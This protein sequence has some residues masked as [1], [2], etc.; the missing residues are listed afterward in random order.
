MLKLLS[1]VQCPLILAQVMAL[2]IGLIVSME[3]EKTLFSGVHISL[4]Q[5]VWLFVTPEQHLNT[6]I[7]CYSYHCHSIWKFSVPIGNCKDVATR[8]IQC[9]KMTM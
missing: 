7:M 3:M 6:I 9:C 8:K 1:P 5:W 4:F 2:L